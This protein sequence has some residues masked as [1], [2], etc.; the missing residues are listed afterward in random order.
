MFLGLQRSEMEIVSSLNRPQALSAST[1]KN[2]KKA[3]RR[4]RLNTC[5]RD[6]WSDAETVALYS[7]EKYYS[8]KLLPKV[9]ILFTLCGQ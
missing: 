8:T 4:Y 3:K 9:E 6:Y 5:E 7:G 1:T 2:R